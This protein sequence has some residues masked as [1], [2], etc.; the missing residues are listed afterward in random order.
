LRDIWK[1]SRERYDISKHLK[2]T[3]QANVFDKSLI[4]QCAYCP[5]RQQ[6]KKF[7]RRVTFHSRLSDSRSIVVSTHC[8][9]LSKQGR[10]ASD[11]LWSA[12]AINKKQFDGFTLQ[13]REANK[14]GTP[15][16]IARKAKHIQVWT[17]GIYWLQLE[18]NKFE[19]IAATNMDIMTRNKTVVV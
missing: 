7:E 13:W 3:V 11:L 14:N 4:V 6:Y 17:S 18:S 10:E 5:Q 19:E 12:W 1:K 2:N 8:D 15:E 16:Y 9:R